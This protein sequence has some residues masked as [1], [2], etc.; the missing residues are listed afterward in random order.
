[1]CKRCK[2]ICAKGVIHTFLF[3]ITMW[4]VAGM[5]YFLLEWVSNL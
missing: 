4:G 3:L 5:A 1:M 2:K